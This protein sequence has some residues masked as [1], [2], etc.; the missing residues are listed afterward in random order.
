MAQRFTRNCAARGYTVMTFNHFGPASVLHESYR[1]V[2]AH[3][4]Q[5]PQW[6]SSKMLRAFCLWMSCETGVSRWHPSSRQLFMFSSLRVIFCA[7]TVSQIAP[8]LMYWSWRISR[9][10]CFVKSYTG[11]CQK[12]TTKMVQTKIVQFRRTIVNTSA[13]MLT[14]REVFFKK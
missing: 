6:L 2:H 1:T 3:A 8:Y 11:T 13:K 5:I 10:R 9:E 14:S 7:V 4:P 12:K